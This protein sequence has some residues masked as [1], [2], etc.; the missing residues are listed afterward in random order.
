VEVTV[1]TPNGDQ[2]IHHIRLL[3]NAAV[4]GNYRGIR[5]WAGHHEQKQADEAVRRSE[6]KF[7]TL[8]DMTGDA[9]MLLDQEGFFDCNQATLT[10]FGC[11][12]PKSSIQ[13][14]RRFVAAEASVRH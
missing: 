12:T 14:I 6:T 2:R 11:T 3:P 1:V 4:M 5:F 9:I 7:R 8:Y 10:V 13:N